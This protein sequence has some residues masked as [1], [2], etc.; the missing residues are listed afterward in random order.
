MKRGQAKVNELQEARETI[1]ELAEQNTWLRDSIALERLPEEEIS[2]A[3][4]T[5][6]ELRAQVKTLEASINAITSMRDSLM[7][8][9]AEMKKQLLSQ[10]NQ[11]KKLA[12]SA[13]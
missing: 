3:Y 13:P 2:D 6:I 11:I 4:E 9:N 5:I 1:A 10:R 12:R 7:R 8:E